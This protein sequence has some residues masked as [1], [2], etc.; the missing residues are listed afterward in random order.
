MCS[1]NC[2]P[3]SGRAPVL[4]SVPSTFCAVSSCI[5]GLAGDGAAAAP[6]RK[7][8]TPGV[9]VLLGIARLRLPEDFSRSDTAQA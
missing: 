8:E 1:K 9:S 5:P 3:I 4:G 6:E 7:R 2:N